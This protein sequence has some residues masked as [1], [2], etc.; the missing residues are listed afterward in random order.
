MKFI[1]LEPNKIYRGLYDLDDVEYFSYF[2][3][4]KFSNTIKD[5]ITNEEKSL[6]D[7]KTVEYVINEND[8]KFY[9]KLY[10]EK[11]DKKVLKVLSP[12]I[13][14]LNENYKYILKFFD[15]EN[16]ETIFNKDLDKQILQN[17]DA[18]LKNFVKRYI[19]E[20]DSVIYFKQIQ[21]YDT[22]F[23][24]LTIIPKN[25]YDAKIPFWIDILKNNHDYQ[26]YGHL[27]FL[28]CDIN[29]IDKCNLL[30]FKLEDIYRD[31]SLL[32][33]K[34][35]E[36]ENKI[37][38]D[39]R[40]ANLNILENKIKEAK[41]VLSNELEDAKK[42]N[43]VELLTEIQIL[44]EE[45]E[46]TKNNLSKIDFNQQSVDWWPSLLYPIEMVVKQNNPIEFSYLEELYKLKVEEV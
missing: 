21:K 10:K 18:K 27:S 42:N 9:S 23:K 26:K 4:D 44:F 7:Y 36:I 40:N 41:E 29:F 16:Y 30:N 33:K 31:G 12:E 5:I 34:Y 13:I 14:E 45:F 17:F 1:N 32:Y 35:I 46:K 43:D 24:K 3:Y 25:F 15:L 28:I 22:L 6:D 37:E 11:K 19:G 2:S 39:Y 8:F 38:E 20:N